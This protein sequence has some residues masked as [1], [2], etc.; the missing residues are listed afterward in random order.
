MT[1][2]ISTE[3]NKIYQVDPQ[4]WWVKFGVHAVNFDPSNIDRLEDYRLL[5]WKELNFGGEAEYCFF[6]LDGG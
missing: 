1:I 4:R 6:L 5:K 2:F 3:Q